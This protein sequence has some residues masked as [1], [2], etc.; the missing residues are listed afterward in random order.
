M[1]KGRTCCSSSTTF[2]A[3]PRP[4]RKFRRCWAA[5][6]R[7]V[8]I[9]RIWRRR[10]ASCR[11]ASRRPKK[12]RSRQCRRFTCRPTTTPIR[13]R[14]RRSPTWMRPRTFR[15]QSPNWEFI[16]PSIRWL[17]PRAFWIPRIIGDEHYNTAQ[18]VKAILQRYKDLQDIIAIL[19]IDELCEEDKLTVA[20]ARK[21]QRF[22]SQPFHV[23]EQFTGF[24]GKYVKLAD[25]IT[26]L[27]GDR[28]W[29]ARRSAG[30][31][32]LHGGHDRG[33]DRKGPHTERLTAMADTL[34]LEVVAP[35]RSLVEEQ[36]SE[37]QVPALRRFHRR[38]AGACASAFRAE[39]GRRADVSRCRW[40]E[41][42]CD[43]RR[44]CGSS[45]GSVRV[46]ADAAERKEE[47]DLEDARR[48][49]REAMAKL[50]KCTA[51]QSIRGGAGGSA[52]RPGESRSGGEMIGRGSG[53][54]LR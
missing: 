26:R 45:A 53:P 41:N 39:A 37:V 13:L 34:L 22:L 30:A 10:W 36:V 1:R 27:Q 31:G 11:S 3:S 15:A 8:A 14:P 2:S 5:C 21:I 52:P 35:E 18:S 23:A 32:V 6:R 46:L 47:I 17:R 25:T 9:S 44:I 28:G 33:S 49:L 29:Q 19:G 4:A 48:R 12:V 43:L 54:K 7:A 50:G 38:P 16:R 24:P 20:R 51:K 40:R 42:P